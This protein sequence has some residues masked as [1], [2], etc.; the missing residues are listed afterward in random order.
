VRNMGWKGVWKQL[1]MVRWSAMYYYKVDKE[2]RLSN[3][4]VRNVLHAF[5]TLTWG[6]LRMSWFNLLHWNKPNW[7]CR[8]FSF[9]LRWVSFPLVLPYYLYWVYRFQV[10]LNAKQ[11]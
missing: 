7:R 3:S 1:F 10:Q 8:W 2:L 5:R 9:T 6:T 4:P 11:K